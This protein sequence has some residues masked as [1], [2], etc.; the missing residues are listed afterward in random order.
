[1]ADERRRELRRRRILENSEARREKIFGVTKS[2]KLAVHSDD[3]TYPENVPVTPAFATST[4]LLDANNGIHNILPSQIAASSKT[5][6]NTTLLSDNIATPIS[7]RENT[8]A[9]RASEAVPQDV[10]DR[11]GAFS[12]AR[13]GGFVQSNNGLPQNRI[14]QPKFDDD[15]RLLNESDFTLR[16]S[17]ETVDRSSPTISNSNLWIPF[18]LAVL[19]CFFICSGLGHVV[20][21][22][23]SL[24]ILLYELQSIMR[25]LYIQTKEPESNTAGL[26]GASLVLCGVSPLVIGRCQNSL[27]LLKDVS[28]SFAVYLVTVVVWQTCYGLPEDDDSIPVEMT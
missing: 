1:M 13:V 7:S 25:T 6:K 26:L 28:S 4:L 5:L 19:S 20:S 12:R 8:L 17:F 27:R 24:P 14:P 10:T 16:N 9:G 2:T 15:P 22:S 21:H 3:E 11:N 23:I 18:I